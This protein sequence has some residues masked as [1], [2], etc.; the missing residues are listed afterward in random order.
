M[1]RTDCNEQ[2]LEK[3][4]GNAVRKNDIISKNDKQENSRVDEDRKTVEEQTKCRT[5]PV[6]DKGA[7]ENKR[8]PEN[9]RNKSEEDS[10]VMDVEAYCSNNDSFENRL[11]NKTNELSDTSKNVPCEE[12]LKPVDSSVISRISK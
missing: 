5:E 3:F 7:M 8:L 2:K 6:K 12:F 4:F 11:L 10:F 9:D 1:V